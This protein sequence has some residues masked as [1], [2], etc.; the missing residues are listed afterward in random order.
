M[1]NHD[2]LEART[3]AILNAETSQERLAAREHR[4]LAPGTGRAIDLTLPDL[5]PPAWVSPDN[6]W[7][8]R[9]EI[10]QWD[11]REPISRYR[12]GVE[13]EPTMVYRDEGGRIQGIDWPQDP[14]PGNPIV[15]WDASDMRGRLAEGGGVVHMGTV[16]GRTNSNTANVSN[17]HKRVHP[18]VHWKDSWTVRLA[19]RFKAARKW[20]NNE[21][22]TAG[23]D[24]YAI[25]IIL[26]G[27]QAFFLAHLLLS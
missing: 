8:Y 26:I 16:T 22:D 27:A 25:L 6:G 20:I 18:W 11:E 7:E 10:N 1:V 23:G 24:I 5:Q 12:D 9:Y 19:R 14:P 17:L 15:H 3:R 2:A 4:V 21:A 13:Q